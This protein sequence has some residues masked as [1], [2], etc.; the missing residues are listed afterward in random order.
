MAIVQTRTFSSASPRLVMA[1]FAGVVLFILIVGF[2]VLKFTAP[3]ARAANDVFE[4]IATRGADAAW[5]DASPDFQQAVSEPRFAAFVTTH[6]LG[7]FRQASWSRT[8]VRG[9]NAY[10][11]GSVTLAGSSPH[12]RIAL[13]HS[14]AG[15]HLQALAILDGA[16]GRLP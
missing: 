14:G 12:A 5:H 16:A 3:A 10:F 11:A 4:T 1:I 6:R 7:T 2:V 9:S 15:W 13:V 8:S